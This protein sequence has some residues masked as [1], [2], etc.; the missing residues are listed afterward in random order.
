MVNLEKYYLIDQVIPP[1]P[2]NY[3][4]IV[5]NLYVLLNREKYKSPITDVKKIKTAINTENKGLLSKKKL[6]SMDIKITL[7]NKP[8]YKSL[9]SF[10]WT[11]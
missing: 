6:I 9:K 7:K 2:G 11:Y 3:F 8:K 1:C 10:F 5:F 4:S